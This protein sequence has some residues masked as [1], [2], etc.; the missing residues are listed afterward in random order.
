MTT[1]LAGL[2]D[3]I[4]FFIIA[5]VLVGAYLALYTLA[6]MHNEFA[7]IRQNSISAATALGFSLVGF[8]LPL[9]SAIVH[10]QTIVDLLVWG[11]VALAVQILVY[12]LVRLVMPNLSQRIASGEMAAALFLGA[13]SLSAGI[14]NAAAM[15][16]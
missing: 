11:I 8:A 14:I 6:T 12:W 16:F 2:F 9:A 5:L 10:A 13:A 3:F 7:L 15:T 1:A 4:V